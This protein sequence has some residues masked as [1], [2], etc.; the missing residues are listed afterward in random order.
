MKKLLLLFAFMAMA[1]GIARSQGFASLHYDVGIPLGKT[2]DEV[3]KVSFRGVGLDFR[4]VVTPGLAAGISLGWQAFYEEK[5]YDTYTDGTISLSGVQFSYL[6][7]VPIL[8]KA[9]YIMGGDED[10][11]RP[12][13]GIGVGTA[14]YERY[15]EMGLF[16]STI[17]TWQFNLEPEVGILYQLSGTKYFFT[18]AK[19][20]QGFKNDDLDAQSYLTI[21]VGFCWRMN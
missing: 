17:N 15:I 11:V 10:T 13:A 12:F 5:D 8:L 3:G 7:V 21:N 14:Y 20:N 2:A 1:G 16:A 19:Y 6:N 9:D 18:A 4:K